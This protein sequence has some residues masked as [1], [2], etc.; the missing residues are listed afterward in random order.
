MYGD[1]VSIFLGCLSL[2]AWGIINGS[3]VASAAS[4]SLTNCSAGCGCS[5]CTPKQVEIRT[6]LLKL[7]VSSSATMRS[8]SRK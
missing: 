5:G 7:G 6:G 2:G 3:A 4:D 8:L 1:G